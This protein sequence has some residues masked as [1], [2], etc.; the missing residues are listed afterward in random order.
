MSLCNNALTHVRRLGNSSLPAD[1]IL[2]ENRGAIN[3]A[4]RDILHARLNSGKVVV[5]KQ[6]SSGANGQTALVSVYDTNNANVLF[7]LVEKSVHNTDKYVDNLAYEHTVGWC[8]NA[9]TY[10]L[11]FWI[12]GT[13]G[14]FS[15]VPALH[16]VAP[17][18][19]LNSTGNIGKRVRRASRTMPW[20]PAVAPSSELDDVVLLTEYVPHSKTFDSVIQDGRLGVQDLMRVV[21]L[22]CVGMACL[23]N[24]RSGITFVHNDL[25]SQNILL[26]DLS[27]YGFYANVRVGK[28]ELCSAYIPY[29]IDYGRLEVNNCFT[30]EMENT[31]R[32]YVFYQTT[33]DNYNDNQAT[34]QVKRSDFVTFNETV[35][36]EILEKHYGDP[37]TRQFYH[38]WHRRYREHLTTGTHQGHFRKMGDWIEESTTHVWESFESFLV[39]VMS[40]FPSD[41]APYR[42]QGLSE[43]KYTIDPTLQTN[44]TIHMD[45]Q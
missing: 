45:C 39:Y 25:H 33:I 11:P 23:N 43:I 30:A 9:L 40:H 27:K 34:G 15:K 18:I 24:A 42:E 5:E 20:F 32:D 13:Y 10:K 16:W 22:V 19:S 7:Q 14:M 29:F 8:I 41:S 4:I 26:V 12:V 44:Y 38:D 3:K 35:V 2:L 37:T 21:M 36:A 28:Y 17:G 6:I 31:G 1:I